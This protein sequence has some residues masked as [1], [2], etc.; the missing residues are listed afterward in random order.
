MFERAGVAATV[1]SAS[2]FSG[3]NGRC[4]FLH[5]LEEASEKYSK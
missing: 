2:I 5:L 4:S 3:M 1:E